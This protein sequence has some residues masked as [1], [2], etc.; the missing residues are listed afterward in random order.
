MYHHATTSAYVAFRKFIL[1]KTSWKDFFLV[2]ASSPTFNYLIERSCPGLHSAHAQYHVLPRG[3][4][5]VDV[6]MDISVL[7]VS[8]SLSLSFRLLPTV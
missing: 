4:N 1:L 3:L 6:K 8:V 5:A 2:K 7:K